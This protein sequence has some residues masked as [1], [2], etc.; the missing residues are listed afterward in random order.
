MLVAIGLTFLRPY[1]DSLVCGPLGCCISTRVG[2][3]NIDADAEAPQKVE[4]DT[5][6]DDND[7]H[8]VSPSES[9]HTEDDSEI[10]EKN[11]LKVA[12]GMPSPVAGSED[13]YA[14][15][16][17]RDPDDPDMMN[18]AD[19]LSNP[20]EDVS[21]DEDEGTNLETEDH[22]DDDAVPEDTPTS[23]KEEVI[24]AEPTEHSRHPDFLDMCCG[25]PLELEKYLT[26]NTKK[27]DTT[28]A[29]NRSESIRS[30]LRKIALVT[31]ASSHSKK[32]KFDEL[33]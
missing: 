5:S 30:S 3:R 19:L 26:G 25:D 33:L 7:E 1:K 23:T 10:P 29:R 4:G 13:K 9:I 21:P 27:K 2:R 32:D 31:E 15:I 22:A 28:F 20:S 17:P 24:V 12:D 11:G 6:E 8:V 16:R 14:R 18:D